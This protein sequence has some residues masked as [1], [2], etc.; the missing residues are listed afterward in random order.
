[1]TRLPGACFA[2]RKKGTNAPACNSRPLCLNRWNISVKALSRAWAPL[3]LKLRRGP[4]QGAVRLVTCEQER[5]QQKTSVRSL[6]LSESMSTESSTD[7]GPRLLGPLLN[8][9]NHQRRQRLRLLLRELPGLRQILWEMPRRLA[10]RLEMWR[11]SSRMPGCG[12]LKN[13]LAPTSDLSARFLKPHPGKEQPSNNSTKKRRWRRRRKRSVTKEVAP[14]ARQQCECTRAPNL[15]VGDSLVARVAG[16]FF[17]QPRPANR[18]Q[19]F[20]G[21]RVK[22]VT[23]EVAKLNLHRDSTLLLT[24]RG[25]DIFLKNR[26]RKCGS[27]EGLVRDFDRLIKMAK[28][29]TSRLIVVGLVPRKYARGRNT[30]GP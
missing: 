12:W 10:P 28:S 26:N 9:L 18:A 27:S 2:W 4:L 1:M 22:K 16:R 8:H 3:W 5:Q 17:S 29:K 6:A 24:V 20:P 7:C 15:L 30:V 14:A 23:E 21:A 11:R 13:P 25:N 19:A